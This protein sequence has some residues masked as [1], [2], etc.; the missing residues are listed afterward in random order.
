MA[1]G[2]LAMSSHEELNANVFNSSPNLINRT[3]FG[4]SKIESQNLLQQAKLRIAEHD[5]KSAINLLNEAI[6]LDQNNADAKFYRAL[7]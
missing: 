4:K 2:S 5:Y 1:P 3:Q 7:S 6:K